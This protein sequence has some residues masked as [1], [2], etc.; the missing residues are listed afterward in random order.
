M[1]TALP[2]HELF[3]HHL[4]HAIHNTIEAIM[5]EEIHKAQERM[6]QRVREQIGALAISVARCADI[7]MMR[8]RLVITVHM[9][10]ETGYVVGSP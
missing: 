1:S 8:D 3:E 6:A 9:D 7:Q 4:R 10:K 5:N 2:T